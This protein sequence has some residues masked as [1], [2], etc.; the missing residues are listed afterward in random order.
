M[1]RFALVLESRAPAREAQR[2]IRALLK[3]ALR[4]FRL[5]C[6]S[7]VEQPQAEPLPEVDR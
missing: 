1:A 3:L 5:R 7:I 6:V 2:A 4:T